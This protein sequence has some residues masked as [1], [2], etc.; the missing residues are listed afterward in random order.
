MKKIIAN[1]KM[2]MTGGEIKNYFIKLLSKLNSKHE[3]V[4][5]PPFTSLALAN[6]FAENSQVVLGAQN[7]CDEDDGACTGEISG[8]LAKDAGASY[9][10][11][12]HSERR[13]KF[14]ENNKII[15]KK[16]KT[17]LKNGLK[18]VLC[19]GE[20]L[21]EKN[22]EK[23]KDVI[24]SQVQDALKGLYENELENITIAYE[25]VWAIG[26][27]KIPSVKDVELTAKYI[28]DVVCEDFSPKAE[29]IEIIYGGSV[30]NKNASTF[31]KI[32]GINGLLVGLASL[33]AEKF[34]QII[35]QL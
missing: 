25:P 9:V 12:G 35:K 18:V 27:G 24:K 23:T 20:T 34:L 3:V 17:A 7:I 19:V 11:V 8:K 16:I 31:A 28:R 26:T 1:F 22:M 29:K 2:N 6:Y 10:I 15:N 32:K 30:D 33:E 14:K 5:C 4:I 13:F 21:A